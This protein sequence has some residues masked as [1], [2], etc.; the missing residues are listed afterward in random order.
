MGVIFVA[1]GVDAEDSAREYAAPVL[2]SLEG[3]FF[4]NTDLSKAVRNY[5]PGK[6][7]GSLRGIPVAQTNYLQCDT[8]AAVPANVDTGIWETEFFTMFVIAR[9]TNL[10]PLGP[11]DSTPSASRTLF[12]GS[13]LGSIPAHGVAVYPSTGSL[14]SALCGITDG[15]GNAATNSVNIAGDINAW[16]LFGV[17]VEPGKLVVDNFTAGTKV[18]QVLSGARRVSPRTLLIGGAYTTAYGGTCNIAAFQTHSANLSSVERATTAQDLR[19][20]AARRGITV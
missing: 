17:T 16:N 3:V 1:K 18:E 14:F 9:A 11:K 12:C 19:A 2:R 13:Y 20:Y 8:Q 7:N 15:I 5:A 4:T 10:P 6:K